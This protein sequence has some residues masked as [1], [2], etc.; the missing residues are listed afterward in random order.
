MGDSETVPWPNKYPVKDGIEEVSQDPNLF[1]G[2]DGLDPQEV[3][4]GDR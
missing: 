3:L 2:D 1:A 4:D